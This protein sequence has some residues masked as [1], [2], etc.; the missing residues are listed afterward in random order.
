MSHRPG[1][2]GAAPM[3]DKNGI[4]IIEEGKEG[5]YLTDGYITKNE[6]NKQLDTL[7]G[8]RADNKSSR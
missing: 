1:H 4:L 7:S 5:G 2:F 3:R 6:F 8:L